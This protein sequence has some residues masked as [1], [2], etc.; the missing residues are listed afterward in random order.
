MMK[1]N[2]PLCLLDTEITGPKKEEGKKS[3]NQALCA[4]LWFFLW[5]CMDVRVGLGRRLSTK[6]LM[7]LNC[8][9]EVDS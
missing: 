8:G 1:Q 5:S 3:A 7:L 4:G 9:V 2:V 6:E